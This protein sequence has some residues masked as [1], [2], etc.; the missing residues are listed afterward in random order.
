MYSTIINC[1][2]Y[3][4]LIIQLYI[5]ITLHHI[6]PYSK[7]MGIPSYFSHIVKKHRTIIKKFNLQNKEKISNLYLDS[8]SIIYD[9]VHELPKETNYAHIEDIIIKS[10]CDKIIYYYYYYYY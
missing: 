6:L 4:V 7:H 8:N 2:Y 5:K 10:V 3:C 9:V 1:I